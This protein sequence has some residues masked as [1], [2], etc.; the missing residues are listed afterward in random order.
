[1]LK[2]KCDKTCV[3]GSTVRKRSWNLSSAR[4]KQKSS[5]KKNVAEDTSDECEV[6]GSD[7]LHSLQGEILGGEAI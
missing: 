6:E 1:V 2:S 7:T 3:L 4:N 5:G